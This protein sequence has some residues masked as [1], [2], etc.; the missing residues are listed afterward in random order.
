MKKGILN[1]QAVKGE[2]VRLNKLSCSPQI[3]SQITVFLENPNP[4]LTD[5]A[6]WISLDQI[7]TARI[8]KLANSRNYGVTGQISTLNLAIITIGLQSL[9][10]LLTGITV[11]DQFSD[12]GYIWPEKEEKFW[13]HNACVGEGARRLSTMVGYPTS[14]EAFIAGLLHD[15]GYQVMAQVY[16]EYF[17]LISR[18]SRIEGIPRYQAERNVL[19][20]DHGQIGGWLASSWNFP[21]NIVSVIEHHHTP[22]VATEHRELVQLVHLADLV[23]HSMNHSGEIESQNN[24]NLEVD[25]LAKFKEYFSINGRS[26]KDMQNLFKIEN[27]NLKLLSHSSVSA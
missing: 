4:S 27:Q 6:E 5:L 25:I 18:H 26:L 8:L 14:G 11:I 17:T 9:K 10:D 13:L 22:D 21:A 16:P 24:S 1:P 15:L 7:L 20:Y 12:V 23:C 3:A 2:V 19:G